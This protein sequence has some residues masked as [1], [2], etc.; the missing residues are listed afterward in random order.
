MEVSL[1]TQALEVERII[2]VQPGFC[3]LQRH[4]SPSGKDYDMLEIFKTIDGKLIQLKEFEE[5]CWIN[6]VNPT[7]HELTWVVKTTGALPE[8]LH[9]ALDDDE[10]SRIEHD[11]DEDQ[12]LILVDIPKVEAEGESY[13]YTT[14]PFGIIHMP[15][16][17]ITVCLVYASLIKEF[18]EN[19]VKG[20]YTFKKTRFVFQLLYQNARR[21]LNY[22]RQI[23]K[24][25]E[26]IHTELQKSYRNKELLQQMSMEKS[27]VYFSTSLKS[28]EAVLERLMRMEFVKRYP[29]DAE[30]LEDVIIE[31]KQAIEMCSIY[32]DILSGTMDAYAS[33]I[34]NNLNIVMKFLAAVTIVM[35]VPQLV[36]ALWG[37]NVAVPFETSPYGFLY[38]C[39]ISLLSV[40]IA[41]IWLY[42]KDMFS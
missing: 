28:N 8:L 36:G 16:C 32:R 38:V 11:E 2:K 23:D 22:L 31:N 25:T 1:W 41:F 30:V 40:V 21:Y 29:E 9:A 20:L 14:L 5:G 26:R 27:L 13:T 6:L 17:L 24:A 34:S 3:A 35:T 4:R 19:K 18:T 15:N 10:R 42:K 12:T 7:S 33:I 37:M 39:L